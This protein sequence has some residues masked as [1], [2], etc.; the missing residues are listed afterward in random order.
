MALPACAPQH[1]TERSMPIA[2][3]SRTLLMRRRIS[4]LAGLLLHVL[5]GA[6]LDPPARAQD[7]VSD[8]HA[9]ALA[10]PFAESIRKSRAARFLQGRQVNGVSAAGALYLAR[11]QSRLRQALPHYTSLGAAWQPVGP[12]QVTTAAFGNVTGRVSA[13]A[14]DDTD[15]TGNTLYV[16]T[17]GGGIW[18]STNAAGPAASVIFTPL[19]DDLPVFSPGTAVTASSASARW[20]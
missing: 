13:L 17:T 18:K 20:R 7:T 2:D 3:L 1:A 9:A 19:T 11:A 6:C 12:R 5:A 8:N 10:Q 16:G 15:P 4:L 14:L